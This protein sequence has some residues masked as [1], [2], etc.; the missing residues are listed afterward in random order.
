M[1]SCPLGC[2][3]TKHGSIKKTAL[4]KIKS[5]FQFFFQKHRYKTAIAFLLLLLLWLFCLPRPL[6]QDPTSTVL[7]DRNGDLLGAQIA[8]D[9]QWRFPV[10]DTVPAKFAAAIIE[11]E[12]R[13][14]YAHWGIDPRGIGRA[15]EQNI[16]NGKVVSGGSTISMQVIRMAR[17]GKP[18]N[19]WQKG[20]EAFLATRLE[21]RYTKDEILAI[22][23]S[24]APFGGNV[25]GLDAASWRYFGKRADLLSWSEAA[26]LAVLPNS[27]SLIH[28]GRNR[29]ALLAKRN[30]LI[31]RLLAKG[32]LDEMT[33]EL[34][35]E[36]PLPEKP[37]P[38]PRLA[39]HLLARADLEYLS[40]K[41]GE[42]TLIPSTIDKHLQYQVNSIVQ[43]HQQR[44][45]H[46]GIHNL[47]ALVLDIQTG[48]VLVYVGNAPNAG[49][50][51]GEAVDIITAPRST[52]SIL[53][54]FL[55]TLMLQEGKILPESIVSDVPTSL[56]GYRPMN[57]H[58]KFDGA[59]PAK[60]AIVRSLNV[61]LVRLLSEYG[62]E[63]FHH[64]LQEM[65][66]S[67][68]HRAPQDYGL[69]LILGGAEGSLWDI[70]NAYACM[71]RTLQNFY[72]NDGEY[73]LN[74]FREAHYIL[75]QNSI[76]TVDNQ[77]LGEAPR[78]S[79]AAIFQTFETMKE[80]ERPNSAGEW[81]RF[82]S[83]KTIAWKT[84][85]SF[86]FRDAWAVG[87][88]SR[89]AVGVWAGNADGEGRPGC[90]G[91]RAAAPVLFDIFDELSASDWFD[92]PYDEMVELEVCKNSGFRASSICPKDTMFVCKGG[93]LAPTCPYHQLLH[94]NE[95]KNLQV[96]AACLP[97]TQMQ[98]QPWF[99]LPPIEAFY[100]KDKHP[101]YRTPPPFLEGCE[102]AQTDL[103]M[104]LIYPRPNTKIYIPT[105]LDGQ[106]SETV[107]NVAHRAPKTTIYWHLNNEY[108][109]KTEDFHSLALRPSAGEHLLVIVDEKGNRVERKFTVVN[110]D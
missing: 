7:L 102:E 62:V 31:D 107:F 66:L 34:A 50:A 42:K 33:A 16:R 12:D 95:T 9:G 4:R 8:T 56:A 3:S 76:Q 6:F 11:F 98:H 37:L 51:H 22:Y 59:V 92:P 106:Q 80:V 97:P 43:R 53:K 85:T 90:V 49:K 99:I 82:Q 18:R 25:V 10:L 15:I 63:K 68:L 2:G 88:T 35:K 45:Q 86:G 41:N 91:V 89:Y 101:N 55:Y 32:L 47:C 75:N 36:E 46:N 105:N 5:I 54:P 48:E 64:E 61:P 30:R 69:T 67:T 29:D 13:R 20:V 28:P 14:F 110:E 52:G 103:P 58:E 26:T 93:E 81:Q 39:P 21:A 83:G 73:Q 87:V 44:L 17:R 70:T 71:A 40:D 109:G 19:V 104:Q 1:T 79:A 60:R 100:Y 23:A 84:G 74:D 57:F 108:V 78:M 72:P 96:T 94:L 77:L 27:P 38:L 24:N 65:G